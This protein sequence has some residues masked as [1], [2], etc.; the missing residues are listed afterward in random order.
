MN[1]L[2]EW[3]EKDC[4]KMDENK[5]PYDFYIQGYNRAKIE[6]LECRIKELEAEVQR[7]RMR[8]WVNPRVF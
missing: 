7:E 8:V 3:F 4:G 2:E 1:K 5:S 6:E